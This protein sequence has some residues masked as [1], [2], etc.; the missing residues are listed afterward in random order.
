[1]TMWAFEWH[2]HD[3]WFSWNSAAMY[4]II[5]YKELYYRIEE[6]NLHNVFRCDVW[7][8]ALAWQ[9]KSLYK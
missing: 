4:R 1:M 5:T 3:N 7:Q 2:D 8:S 6:L 9:N